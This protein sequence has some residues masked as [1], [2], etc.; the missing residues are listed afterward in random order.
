MITVEDFKKEVVEMAMKIGVKPK[1]IHL[2]PMTKKWGSCSTRG[3]LSFNTELL[4]VSKKKRKEIIVH[5]LLHL[6]YTSHNKM[7]NLLYKMHTKD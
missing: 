2:R 1:E 3:R 7:F 6:R 4:S 5:E